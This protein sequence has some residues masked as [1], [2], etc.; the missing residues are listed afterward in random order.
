MGM[1]FLPLDN[2]F[3]L[4]KRNKEKEN[5]HFGVGGVAVACVV[6]WWLVEGQDSVLFL[7]SL[8]PLK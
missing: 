2:F 7:Y 3:F 1:V 8:C 4:K 6:G 5:I